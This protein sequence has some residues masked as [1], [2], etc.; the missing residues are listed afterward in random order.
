MAS[1]GSLVVNI[2]GDGRPLQ[3]SLAT[4]EKRVR[5]FTSRVT[6]IVRA[7][8]A[9]LFSIKSMLVGIVTAASGAFV[10]TGAI[11]LAA[12]AETLNTQFEV[13]TGNAGTA[14][15]LMSE[16][17]DFAASTPFQKMDIAD[18]ARMLLAFGGNAGTV[19][20]E[21]KMLGD[22]SAGTGNSI[23]EL[24]ELYGKAKVQGRLFGEDINQLTGRG[25][26]VIQELAKQ[27]GVAD[28]EVKKLVEQGKVGFPELQKALQAMTRDGGK[29]EGLMERLS[30]TTAGKWST[31]KDNV[32]L[33][34]TEIG[35]KLLPAANKL[36][37]WATKFS[38]SIDVNKL[39]TFIDG[40]MAPILRFID[41]LPQS[42]ELMTL[43]M[44]RIW[45]SAVNDMILKLFELEL[46][47]GTMFG[48]GV[49]ADF[50]ERLKNATQPMRDLTDKILKAEAAIMSLNAASKKT[51]PAMAA[52]GGGLNIPVP[53]NN[54]D[55]IGNL[56]DGGTDKRFGT[57]ADP[58]VAGPRGNQ[59]ATDFAAAMQR[60]SAEAFSAVLR[61]NRKSPEV[62][63]TEK[64]TKEL[65]KAIEKSSMQMAGGGLALVAEFIP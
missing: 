6:N 5:T 52:I 32:A 50:E 58:T 53:D 46:K 18:A 63:A 48:T 41:T 55:W 35:E 36:L 64:Q 39:G 43:K 17:N 2:N 10:A 54:K 16:I 65:V 11:K 13:L 1:I 47:A 51:A 15:Q 31:F 45:V 59:Q 34:A 4:A 62:D 60:G 3:K 19:V 57:K 22:L 26:P 37:D 49:S 8:L 7:G 29:F 44:Q 38:Q 61:S 23:G 12:E 21:L 30:Q 27:F 14:K 24:A 9:G 28:G 33:T 40:A 42:W 20:D 56:L 25:I